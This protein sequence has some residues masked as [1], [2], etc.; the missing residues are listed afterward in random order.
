MGLVFL[1]P[2]SVAAIKTLTAIFVRV[3]GD[4]LPLLPEVIP[5]IAESMEDGE[6]EVEAEAQD[7]VK[8]V[9]ELLG[10]SLQPYFK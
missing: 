1:T 5:S 6:D 7:F 8:T 9:E 2:S 10:E 3:G 4:I